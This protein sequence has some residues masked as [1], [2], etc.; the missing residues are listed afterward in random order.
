[1][2]GLCVAQVVESSHPDY[3]PGE[4]V[5]GVFGWQDYALSDGGGAIPVTQGAGGHAADDAAQRARHHEPDRVLRP[6][7]DRAS[8][9]RARRSPCRA[10]PV[11]P[12]RSRV[13]SRSSWG[14]RVIGIAGGPEKCDWLTD[15][16][17]FDG[18]IDYKSEN[19]SHTPARALPG[20]GERVLGQRRRLGPRGGPRKPRDARARRPVRRDLELQRRATR[21]GR[22]TT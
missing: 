1:M 11:R 19:V 13:S 14:C 5:V 6:E 21:R 3:S 17:G 10:P 15:E 9:R 16:L 8:R 20:R 7:G 12:A 4:L 22:A 18:A 2:R